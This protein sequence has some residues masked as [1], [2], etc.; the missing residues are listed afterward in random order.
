MLGYD[1]VHGDF[2][3]SGVEEGPIG[4]QS[5]NIALGDSEFTYSQ[6]FLDEWAPGIACNL[7]LIYFLDDTETEQI[8]SGELI[9][10]VIGNNMVQ[11][12][13]AISQFGR[14]ETPRIPHTSAYSISRGDEIAVNGT[15]Y[16]IT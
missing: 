14:E 5:L 1:W 9:G 8:F 6:T 12:T 10:P 4:P 3:L 15:T 11:V 16:V 2:E 7:W 13:A